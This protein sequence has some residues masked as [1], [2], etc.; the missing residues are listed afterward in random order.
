MTAVA[1]RG[2]IRAAILPVSSS[3]GRVALAR[4]RTRSVSFVRLIPSRLIAPGF[5]PVNRDAKTPSNRFNGFDS[6]GRSQTV[7]FGCLVENGASGVAEKGE[8]ICEVR[9]GVGL[10]APGTT[11]A[12]GH[13]TVK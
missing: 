7:E 6:D 12:R 4:K 10:G 1:A 3:S 9:P 5:N 8:P 2:H 13:K 11:L